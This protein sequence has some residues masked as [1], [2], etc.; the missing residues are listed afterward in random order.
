MIRRPT[1]LLARLRAGTRSGQRLGSLIALGI[2]GAV[3]ALI[4]HR[5]V[6]PA[7]SARIDR[8]IDIVVRETGRALSLRNRKKLVRELADT[9]IPTGATLRAQMGPLFMALSQERPS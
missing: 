3:R 4:P 9:G 5:R 2:E 7:L 1:M 6:H 8:D